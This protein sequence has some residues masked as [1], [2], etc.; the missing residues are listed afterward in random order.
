LGFSWLQTHTQNEGILMLVL[1][2]QT[3]G[4]TVALTNDGDYAVRLNA[5]HRDDPHR[6]S[7]FTA[8][9]ATQ[10]ESKEFQD[11][12]SASGLTTMTLPAC[13]EQRVAG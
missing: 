13:L 12:S 7:P 11:W 9:A 6:A 4:R 5:E 3:H 1:A 10:A 8:R 2:I